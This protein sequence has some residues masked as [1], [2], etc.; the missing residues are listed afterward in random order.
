MPMDG[1][2]FGMIAKELNQLLA[3]GRVDKVTQPERD[4]VILLIRNGGE[5]HSLL[6]S[7][8][9]ACARAHLTRVKKANPLE[10]PNLCMLLRKHLLGGRLL[11]VRQA[12]SDRILEFTFE[13]IDELGD[14]ARKT[15]IGEFMGKHSNLIFVSAD[16]RI[17]ESARRITEN[18]SSFREVVPGV[19]YCRPPAHGK[20]PFD[21][22]TP[23]AVASALDGRGGSLAKAL[24]GAVSGLS[25]PLARELAYR[26]T[27]DEDASMDGREVLPLAQRL[28]AEMDA[29]LAHPE[30]R[31][32]LNENGET[33]E[34]TA[35]AYRSREG[36]R[37]RAYVTLSEAIDDFYFSR[38]RE[39]RIKQKSAAIHRV[40]KN[41]IERVEKKLLIKQEALAEGAR[42]E[43]YRVKGEMLTASPHLVKKGMKRVL[44]PNY[45]DEN[46]AMLE[47]EL[48]EKL[49]AAANAQRYFKLYR[50]AQV[51]RKLAEEQ[52]AEATE[53]LAYLENQLENLE[54][55]EGEA[56]LAEIR[57]EL[58]RLG[59][60]RSTQSR[61]Q[62]KAL[63]PST[64]LR[65]AAPDGTEVFVGRNNVQ[66]ERLTFSAQPDEWWLHAKDMPGSHVIVKSTRPS[67]ET[68]L[69]AAR[70]A[71]RYSKG[72]AS[73]SVPVDYTQ[74]RQV[75]KPGGAK[76]GF[77][78]YTHQKTLLVKPQE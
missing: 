42:S 13:H 76:P 48:D 10:P 49:N 71:A 6:L 59:Y 16:G 78:I 23:E 44:L 53:E 30:P 26:L 17:I 34:F 73:S 28:C 57:E 27:G 43:E 18:I 55:C 63:P 7:A 8:S 52:I 40:L 36:Q 5:N 24:M 70:L 41:N 32:L 68:L 33:A 31:V 58:V 60:I 39:E 25:T 3:G 1:V 37:Y 65:F 11:S 19:D 62:M 35:F 75:K 51:A 21:Q 12:E 45:Y 46:C 38:D 22:L 14:H 61:R 29:I 2:T 64:P 50:K 4:E 66:N 54:L 69:F 67:D 72:S 20:L 15:L 56:E 74:R 9:P 47:V 77:V